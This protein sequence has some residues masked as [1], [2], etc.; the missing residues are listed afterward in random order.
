MS[1]LL[2]TL[3]HSP[4]LQ[5]CVA[6]QSCPHSPQLAGSLWVFTHTFEQRENPELQLTPQSPS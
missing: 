4:S 5:T 3:T 6:L 1:P 2:H